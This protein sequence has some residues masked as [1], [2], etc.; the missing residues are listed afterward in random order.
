MGWTAELNGWTFAAF[1]QGD[2]ERWVALGSTVS[3]EICVFVNDPAQPVGLK[4]TGKATHCRR[5]LK[6]LHCAYALR[7]VVRGK[8]TTVRS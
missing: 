3:S 4:P 5:A 7:N 1:K 6:F 8:H 2:A